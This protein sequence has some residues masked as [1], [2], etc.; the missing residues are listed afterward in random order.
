M[1]FEVLILGSD[2]NA[3]YMARNCYEEYHKKA[4]LIGMTPMN[5]TSLSNILEITYVKDS[6]DF[7]IVKDELM[8]FYENNKDKKILLVPSNDNYVR[9]M[10]EN[11]EFLKQYFVFH[12]FSVELLNDLLVKDRFYTKFADKNIPKTYIYNIEDE[13]DLNRVN[14]LGYELILKPGDGIEYHNHEFEGQA[15]VFKIFSEEE[16]LNVIKKIK[17]SGYKGNLILQEFIAGDDSYLFDCISYC[18]KNGK[19]KLMS[20]AQIALQEHTITGIGNCTVLVNGFNEYN[21]TKETVEE[22]KAFL[23]TL[24]YHGICEFDLK[25]DKKTNKFKILE[26]NPRQARSSYY[27]TACGYNLVKYLVDELIYGKEFDFHFIDDEMV[28]SF[29]PMKVIKENVTNEKIK[30]EIIKLRKQKKCCDP[31]NCKEDKHL[32]RK[33]WLFLRKINF[34][35]KYRK[36]KW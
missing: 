2:I 11:Q 36:C 12:T 34:V 31:L 23:E 33:I 22:L 14:E 25:Y 13:L 24:N 1:D 29:V 19:V 21:N 4:H 3:Y 15:K 10:Q 8:K 30:K 28:L 5:F 20:F 9:L 16:L 27:L 26:I 32:K 6:H 17:D 35:K 18:D 7:N